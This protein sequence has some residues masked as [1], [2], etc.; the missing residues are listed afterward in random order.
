MTETEV[1]YLELFDHMNSGVAVYK[2]INDG[3]DFIFVDLNKKG[4]SISKIK[5]EDVFGKS[6]LETFPGV[7]SSGLLKVFQEVWKTGESEH[8]PVTLYQDERISH[9]M[10]NYIYKLDSGEI[11]AIYDDI[12]ELK[13]RE[14]ELRN[15][16]EKYRALVTSGAI[17]VI[18]VSIKGEALEYNKKLLDFFG[19]TAE[20]F[21]NKTFMELTHSE[22]LKADVELFQEL[23]EGKRDHYNIEKRYIHKEGHIIWGNLSV[24]IIRDSEG[25]SQYALSLV[26]D[27]TEKKKAEQ[28]LENN[29]EEKTQLADILMDRLPCIALLLRPQ[30]REIVASNKHAKEVG[31]VPGKSCYGTWCQREDPCPWCLAPK[32]WETKELQHLEFEAS[33][34]VW[35][36]YWVPINEDLYLHYAFDITERKRA[37]QKIKDSE[38]KYRSFYE[39]APLPYQS[40]DENGMILDVNQAWLDFFDYN[41]EDVIGKWIGDFMTPESR[42]FLT[43]RFPQFKKEGTIQGVQYEIVIKDGT[44]KIISFNGKVGYDQEGNFQRTHCIFED[45]T[46]KRRYEQKLKES[47]E[48]YKSLANLLPQIIAETDQNGNLTFV[49]E[50]AFEAFG[51]THDDYNRGIN[52]R[53]VLIPEDRNRATK[54][55]IKLLKGEKLGGNEYMALRKNGSTFPILVYSNP[56]IRKNKYEGFRSI[57]IDITKRKEAKQK[58]IDS[59]QK[60]KYLANEMEMILDHIPALVIYKDTENNFIQVNKYVADAHNMSKEELIGRNLFDL[61]PREEAQAYWD[62]DLE[63]LSSKQPKLNIVEPWETEEGRRWVIT[64]RIPHIDEN[65]DVKG[66]IVISSDITERKRAEEEVVNLAKF[67]SENPNP[68]LRVAKEKV[69]YINKSGENLFNIREGNNIPPI[70]QDGV[71]MALDTNTAK[72]MEIELNNCIYSIDITPIKG[73]EYAN[74]YGKDITE[75]KQAEDALRESEHFLKVAQTITHIG[76]WKLNPITLEVNGSDELFHI[77]GLNRDEANLDAFLEVVHPEDREYDAFHIKRGM[78]YGESWDIEHRLVTRD[79]AEKW[80]HAIGE[81]T[82]DDRGKVISLIGTVQDITEHKKSE[83]KIKEQNEF[84]TNVIESLTHPFYVININDY[85]IEMANTAANFGDLSGDQKC[86]ILTHQNDKPCIGEHPCPINIVK[87]TKSP[88]LVEHIHYDEKGNPRNVDIHGYPIFDENGEAIQMIE[89]ALDITEHRKAERKIKEQ[90]EFLTNVIESLTHPFYIIN[91]ND[92]T[93]EMA[94]TAANFG[95]FSGDQKCFFLTHQNDKPCIGEHPCP[96]NMVKNTKSPVH[97]EH[98]HYDEKGNPRNVDIHGYPIFDENGEVIQM[99]EYALDITEHRKAEQKLIES[100]E[101]YRELVETSPN[102]IMLLDY[103]GIIIECN[104][105]TEVLLDLLRKEIIGKSFIELFVKENKFESLEIFNKVLKKEITT[106]LEFK[107]INKNGSIIYLNNRFSFVKIGGKEYIQFVSE[108]ITERKLAENLI[109]EEVN[110]LKALDQIKNDFIDRISHELKTPLV[111]IMGAC[112]LLTDIYQSEMSEKVMEYINIAFRGGNRLKKLVDNL[113]DASRINDQKLELNK[114]NENLS[115]II[116]E[117]INDLFASIIKRTLIINMDIEEDVYTD[118]D[119]V[120]IEQ[121]FTN[122]ISNAIKN[123]PPK[124]RISIILREYK[125]YISISIKDTGIGL[126]EEEK[127]QIFKKFGKIERYGKGFDVDIDGSGLGLFI[128]KNIVDLHNGTIGVESEGRNKGCTFNVKLPFQ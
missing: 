126:T 13:Q 61:Y 40:L 84:L 62:D 24:A 43:S 100:E 93:I 48:K 7:K 22:D 103:K 6:L 113:I 25:N 77:F 55:Y 76:H 88:T 16:E 89:Y 124:G 59:E 19:Y 78:D 128:S 123:T 125:D 64:S 53:Q 110:K 96:I 39:H 1:K 104:K 34:I 46:E 66:T 115:R 28:L 31:A 49:N 86:F 116:K 4:E 11:V 83:E 98:I 58:I 121:V 29:L 33:D 10:E 106:A 26:E 3:N 107:Y 45:I 97:V 67:P 70:I 15:S 14:E 23:I 90:N 38:E 94:N 41:R 12:T 80:V 109:K 2:A 71:N 5:R 73:E 54:N 60:Y 105:I 21:Q 52:I 101:K 82:L 72:T 108:N 111:S 74:V 51:Y 32:A 81:A 119:R 85:T 35:D 42:A 65:G 112:E 30:T 9:W 127:K 57:I 20:E 91:I 92:Y 122:L 117:C 69:I 17:G 68:V 36:A 99:I 63:V 120:K 95:D 56:I 79:S 102:S 18:K 47:E 50:N 8:H 114:K 118:V 87:N 75:R 44:H 37:E 27:I